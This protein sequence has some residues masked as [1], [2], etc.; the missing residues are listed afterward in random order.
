MLENAKPGALLQTK[1]L[2]FQDIFSSPTSQ[3]KICTVFLHINIYV[4]ISY[5]N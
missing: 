4:F 2:G 3:Y 1:F 5:L